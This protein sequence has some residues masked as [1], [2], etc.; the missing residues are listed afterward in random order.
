LNLG[1]TRKLTKRAV[2]CADRRFASLD[3]KYWAHSRGGSLIVKNVATGEVYEQDTD[4]VGVR[5]LSV[6]RNNNR[7]VAWHPSG[8]RVVFTAFSAPTGRS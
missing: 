2:R 8:N 6:G 7:D 3:G 5:I 1:I 4:R